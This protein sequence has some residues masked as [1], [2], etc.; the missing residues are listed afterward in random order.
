[1]LKLGISGSWVLGFG[2]QVLDFEF[3]I[4]GLGSWVLVFVIST[5]GYVVPFLDTFRP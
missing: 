4:L 1:M 3:W 5:S 2:Y